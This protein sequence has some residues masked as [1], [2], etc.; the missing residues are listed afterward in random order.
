MA[1]SAD[2][3]ADRVEQLISLTERLTALM[4]QDAADFEAHQPHNAASRATEGGR[5]ANLYRHESARVR[6]EP[7]L[8]AGAPAERRAALARATEA[9]EQVLQ[10]H[11]RALEAAK[12]VTEGLVR[13]IA[14]EA[15]AQRGAAG[16]YGPSARVAQ[17]DAAPIALNRQA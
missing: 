3:A 9:M 7:S 8:I 13:A 14:E 11:A 4:A 5:L 10:R 6:R 17:A 12:A 1:I 16:R 2:N 15:T